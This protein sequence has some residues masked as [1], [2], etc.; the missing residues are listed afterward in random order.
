LKQKIKKCLNCK[1]Y[2]LFDLC[3]KCGDKTY[4]A[5]PARFSPDD[6][7]ALY[8]NRKGADM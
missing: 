1:K 5:H 3:N 7:Y 2:T 8:K 4:T 6:K